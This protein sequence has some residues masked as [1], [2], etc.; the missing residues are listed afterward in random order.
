MRYTQN[1]AIPYGRTRCGDFINC[2]M[3]IESAADSERGR[4]Y[5]RISLTQIK[6]LN[7]PEMTDSM[8]N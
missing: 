8:R 4:A 3:D 2:Y 1:A 6:G 7:S 5:S